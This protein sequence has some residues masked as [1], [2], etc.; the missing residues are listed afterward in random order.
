MMAPAIGR[1]SYALL[2]PSHS[3]CTQRRKPFSIRASENRQT[4]GPETKKRRSVG[5][6]PIHRSS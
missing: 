3:R 2:T 4:N 5:S 6:P 1:P